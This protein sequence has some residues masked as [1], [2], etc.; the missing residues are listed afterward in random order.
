MAGIGPAPKPD[1]ERARRNA[2]TFAW[3]NL[4]ARNDADP[5]PLPS[6][7]LDRNGTPQLWSAQAV[8]AWETLWRSPQSTQW[9]AEL[10]PVVQQWLVM[11]DQL[12]IGQG[13]PAP[14]STAMSQLGD[15]LGLSPKALL[16]LRWR[17]PARMESST[18]SPLAVVSP[19]TKPKSS[20]R[21]PR[22]T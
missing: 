1:D 3:L 14:L 19:M 16:M 5:P 6:R 4:P 7:P 13:S 8:E 20:R 11:F 15:R 21:D 22:T 10:V 2:P 18:S 9:H 17:V 12:M